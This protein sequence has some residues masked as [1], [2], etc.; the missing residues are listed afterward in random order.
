MTFG[1]GLKP[2]TASINRGLNVSSCV[3]VPLMLASVN[4]RDR[5]TLSVHGINPQVWMV[6]WSIARPNVYLLVFYNENDG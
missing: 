2:N 5:E 4:L 6:N 3:L 1:R